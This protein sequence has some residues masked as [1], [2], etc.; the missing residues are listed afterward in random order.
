[1]VLRLGKML[2]LK[3]LDCYS[4][5]C[6][7]ALPGLSGINKPAPETPAEDRLL[8]PWQYWPAR[9]LIKRQVRSGFWNNAPQRPMPASRQMTFRLAMEIVGRGG[10]AHSG[11]RFHCPWR[12][13]GGAI[14]PPGQTYSQ[15]VMGEHLGSRFA[16]SAASRPGSAARID[17]TAFL[18]G[19]WSNPSLGHRLD[20]HIRRGLGLRRHLFWTG[21][22]GAGAFP[23]NLCDHG[24]DSDRRFGRSPTLTAS[25]PTAEQERHR[26][27][28]GDIR[29]DY[30]ADRVRSCRQPQGGRSGSA[31]G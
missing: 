27:A 26:T 20:C 12:H 30:R 19:V 15:V 3:R 4:P 10:N 16:G 7:T 17:D 1:M 24:A 29:D 23:G 31:S 18:G 28:R 9:S 22:F 14:F 25:R 5:F 21:S 2:A 11:R 8:D 13:D 6:Q